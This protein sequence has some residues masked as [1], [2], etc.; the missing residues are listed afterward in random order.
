MKYATNGRCEDTLLKREACQPTT[1]TMAT[2][3]CPLSL[4]FVCSEKL[5]LN[6]RR[7]SAVSSVR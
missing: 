3:A 7:V 5:G 1:V 2:V 4:W 6:F